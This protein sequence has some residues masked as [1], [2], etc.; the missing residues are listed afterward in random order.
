MNR[1]AMLLAAAALCAA[2]VYA[3]AQDQPKPPE[4]HYRL[5]LTLEELSES[6]QVRNSRV[7][8]ETIQT[9]D[10]HPQQVR[11][12]TRVPFA[13][14]TD[15]KNST[16]FQYV[17]IGVNFDVREVKE[18]GDQLAFDLAAEVSSLA[19]PSSS[20]SRE[21]STEP[22]I[23]QNKWDAAVVIPIGKP[24]VV[25]SADD[26]EGKGKMQVE[27]TATRLP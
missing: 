9:N 22:I 26:L 12:G 13:T 18:V 21:L 20:T 8:V 2:P 25:F 1:P 23:R 24:T 19:P 16:S 3:A 5:N 7:F 27:L 14:G 11:T 4:H 10:T 6:G 17:D 15:E